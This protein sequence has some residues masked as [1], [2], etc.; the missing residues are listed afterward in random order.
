MVS[1]DVVFFMGDQRFESSSLQRRVCCEPDSRTIVPPLGKDW[2][3]RARRRNPDPVTVPMKIRSTIY[4]KPVYLSHSLAN[5]VRL[6]RKSSQSSG[7]SNLIFSS[8]SPPG[9]GAA[10]CLGM[11]IQVFRHCLLSEIGKVP[12]EKQSRRIGMGPLGWNSPCLRR[13]RQTCRG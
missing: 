1:R 4:R 9:G 8:G 2:V 5:A 11:E 3:A 10:P 6:L 12:V 7:I 13:G